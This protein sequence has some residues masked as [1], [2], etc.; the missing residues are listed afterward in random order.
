VMFQQ[1]EVWALRK[2]V[3]GYVI[4]PAFDVNSVAQ[5]TKG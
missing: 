4:G 1:I 2:K 5:A 3:N